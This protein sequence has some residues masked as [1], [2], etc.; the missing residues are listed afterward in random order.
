MYIRVCLQLYHYM[1]FKRIFWSDF[2]VKIIHIFTISQAFCCYLGKYIPCCS[3]RF[4]ISEGS[5]AFF[6]NAEEYS[7]VIGHRWFLGHSPLINDQ[8][9][10][11]NS[12]RSKLSSQPEK[13]TELGKINVVL[14]PLVQILK[15][16][17][18][19]Y[20]RSESPLLFV[21]ELP[22]RNSFNNCD[23]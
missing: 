20:S 6:P 23:S 11:V 3:S 15:L 5:T 1:I 2:F 18:R 12:V 16:Q 22:Y 17:F 4:S 21:L 10:S 13:F 19:I 14:S 7:G 8:A 9:V